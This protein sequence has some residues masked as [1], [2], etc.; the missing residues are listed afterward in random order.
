MNRL[1]SASAS[2]RSA[3]LSGRS[4]RLSAFETNLASF[5]F[6]LK[7]SNRSTA[8]DGRSSRSFDSRRVRWSYLYYT[9]QRQVV[10]SGNTRNFHLGSIAHGVWEKEVPQKLKQFADIVYRF[11]LQRQS[12]CEIFAHYSPRDSWRVCFMVGL[13]NTLGR[14]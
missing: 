7:S 3:D 1:N 12:K 10:Y 13:S 6:L 9:P 2:R 14:A 5:T 11:S 8:F 4:R